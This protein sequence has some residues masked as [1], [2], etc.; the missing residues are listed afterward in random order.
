MIARV[1]DSWAFFA[2]MAAALVVGA[3]SLRTRVARD[4][5]LELIS[6]ENTGEFWAMMGALG[7]FALALIAARGLT[8]LG[9]AKKEIRTRSQREAIAAAIG[10]C[11]AFRTEIIPLTSEF[12]ARL[13]ASAVPLFVDEPGKVQ[14]DNAPKEE[15]NRAVAW[16][17][18][19]AP[20]MR[21]LA[22]RMLNQLE[23]WS[24]HFTSNLADSKL[25]YGPTSTIFCL[26]VL[27]AYP[28]L[29]VFREARES[30]KFSNTVELY[31][32]WSRKKTKEEVDAQV[33]DLRM[34]ASKIGDHEHPP[35]IGT[36]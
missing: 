4:Q 24:M 6:V 22:I 17:N 29:L 21:A 35:A 13:A 27:R 20:E 11:E 32:R 14:W 31:E 3:Y 33:Q 7:T 36:I 12:Q 19:L 9:L 1:K 15:I 25:A 16:Y 30:G 8:S 23:A 28:V 10:A 26:T 18:S 34:K 5:F 2:T